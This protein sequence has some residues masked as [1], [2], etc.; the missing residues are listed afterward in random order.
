MSQYIALDLGAESGRAIVGRLDGEKLSLEEAY[1]FPNGAVRVLNS[2]HWDPLRLLNE[3]KQSLSKISHRYGQDFASVGVDTWGVDFALLD[4]AGNLVGNPYCYRDSRTEGMMEEAF[5]CLSRQDIFE[6]TGGIQFLSINSLFQMLAMAVNKSPQLEI[7][8]TFLMMPDLFNYWL[9]GQKVC[10]FTNATTT[11]FYNSLTG[12]WSKNVLETLGM[13]SDIF[14]EVVMPGTQLGPLLPEITEEVGLKSL[15]VVAPATHDTASAAVAVPASGDDFVWLSSGTWSLLGGISDKPL[16]TPEALSY[17][18]SSYGG[19][20]GVCLPWK[21]IMGLWLV[22]ECR[23]I[24]TRAGEELSYGELTRMARAARPFTAVV[25]PDHPS[26]LAPADM[27]AAIQA[28]CR[29]TRQTVP[30]SKG[31]I[32]RTALEGLALKYRWVV[33]KLEILLNRKFNAL[34]VVGGGSQNKLLCQFAADAT[35]LPVIAGP[36]EATAI[37]NIAVQAV[38]TGHLASLDEAR[39]VIRRSFGVVTYEPAESTPWHEA[40]ERFEKLVS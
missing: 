1:R 19:A 25:E 15:P 2:L 23:R 29:D 28:Y 38:A 11:Q 24:W 26:F 32:V 14:P 31:E 8:N 35:G 33:D 20:G 30:D 9:T 27:P 37:G 34:H 7:A 36:V 40:Y 12:S 5:K 39:Q 22:Q 18:F 10:E 3:M 21:N 13:P 16:V 6:Q 17:N 4:S